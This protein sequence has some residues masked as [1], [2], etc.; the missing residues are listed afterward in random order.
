MRFIVNYVEITKGFMW[1]LKKEVP[2]V[3]D[4]FAQH[5]FDA[6][7]KALTFAPPLSPPDYSRDFLLYLVATES[8][9]STVLVQ[10]DEAVIKHVIFYLSQGLVSLNLGILI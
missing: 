2:F 8:T 1:L 4:D 3:W 6:L 9:T 5:S 7:K 10:E